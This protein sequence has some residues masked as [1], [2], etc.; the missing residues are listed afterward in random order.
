[1]SDRDLLQ[2]LVDAAGEGERAFNLARGREGRV[3]VKSSSADLVTE[4][5]LRVQEA[6]SD[7]LRRH[8]PQACVVAEEA[9]DSVST[10]DR[11]YLDPIDGTLNFVH[12]FGEHC[13]SIGYRSGERPLAGVVRKLS[14]GDLFAAQRGCG[15]FRNGEAIR[16]SQ[17]RSTGEALVATGWPYDKSLAGRVLSQMGRVIGQCQEIRIIG[18]AA[19]AMC[20][21]ASGVLEGFWETGLEP[22]DLAAG[23]AIALEAGAVVTAHDG[24]PFQLESGTILVSNGHL[25]QRLIEMIA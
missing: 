17:R 2:V 25:H 7:F 21:V 18:S 24:S 13:I 11:I 16:P 20:Y 8:V 5:D 15:A 4:V 19:L 23:T 14:T 3:R 10:A 9:G 12:G 6:T 22:W 1:M